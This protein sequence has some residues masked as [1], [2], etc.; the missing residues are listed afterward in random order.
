[1][2]SRVGRDEAQDRNCQERCKG[3]VEICSGKPR[4]DAHDP[5][6]HGVIQCNLETHTKELHAVLVV[7]VAPGCD[8]CGVL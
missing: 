5:R 1:M 3:E 6:Q 4:D 8:H 7:V 2:K